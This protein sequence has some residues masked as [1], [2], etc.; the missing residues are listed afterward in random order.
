MEKKIKI[1]K[2]T[3][4][5]FI[6]WLICYR[7]EINDF[8][9]VFNNQPEIFS[10]LGNEYTNIEVCTKRDKEK[11]RRFSMKYDKNNKPY[12]TPTENGDLIIYYEEWSFNRNYTPTTYNKISLFSKISYS[13]GGGAGAYFAVLKEQD[14]EKD[15]LA[16]DYLNALEKEY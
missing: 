9:F 11:A 13:N 2:I 16:L 8:Y 7:E 15:D 3:N 14:L 1:K 5:F 6:G 12:L 10:Y 4:D